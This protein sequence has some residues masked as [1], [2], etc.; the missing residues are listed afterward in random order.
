[1]AHIPTKRSPLHNFHS[2]GFDPQATTQRRNSSGVRVYQR[3]EVR[4]NR[5][6]PNPQAGTGP[7]L[8]VD[9]QARMDRISQAQ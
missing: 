9:A 2:I 1:V 4:K 8:S 5:I 6:R 3:M 7:M